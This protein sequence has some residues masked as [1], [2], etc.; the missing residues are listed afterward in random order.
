LGMSHC[1][2]CQVLHNDLVCFFRL[3]TCVTSSSSDYKWVWWITLL[4]NVS[5]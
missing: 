3:P 5:L 2:G 4:Q 1:I